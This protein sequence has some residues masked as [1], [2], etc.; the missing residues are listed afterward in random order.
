MR[1][2]RDLTENE[3]QFADLVREHLTSA[4]R[5][6]VAA[7]FAGKLRDGSIRGI[8][9]YELLKLAAHLVVDIDKSDFVAHS[10]DVF[11]QTKAFVADHEAAINASSR[12]H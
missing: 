12:V 9:A 11:E 4:G 6:L 2:G 3:K 10:S 5:L 8:L 1:T 7:G